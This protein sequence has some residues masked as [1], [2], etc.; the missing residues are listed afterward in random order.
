[1]CE[2]TLMLLTPEDAEAVFASV[3]RLGGP[4]TRFLFTWLDRGL[5]EAAKAQNIAKVLN[6]CGSRYAPATS[7]S[8]S[9]TS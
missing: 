1:M 9:A 8:A 5:L 2:G 3:H 6:Y 7:Q 4:G